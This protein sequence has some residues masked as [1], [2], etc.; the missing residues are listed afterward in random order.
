[1]DILSQTL[2]QLTIT[3]IASFNCLFMHEFKL[4]YVQSGKIEN[5]IHS[6]KAGL[7]SLKKWPHRLTMQAVHCDPQV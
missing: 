4:L 5:E 7:L 3:A 1:M 2:V 6:R